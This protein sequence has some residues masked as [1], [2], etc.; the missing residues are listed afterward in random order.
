MILAELKGISKYFGSVT[1]VDSLNLTVKQG[2]ILAI[3]GPSG[4]G[5]TTLLQIISGLEKADKG[6]IRIGSETIFSAENETFL[7]PELRQVALVFQKYALWPH[8]NV[9]QNI[10]YPLKIKRLS[11]HTIKK[12]V[13]KVLQIIRLEGKEKRYPHELSGGE[14]QRVALARALVMKPKLLLLDEPLSNLDAKLREDMQ[15]E[16]KRIQQDLNL[17][18]IHVTHDQ[19]EAMGIADRLAVMNNGKIIQIGTPRDLYEQPADAFVAQFIGVSNLLQ[20]RI[21]D[22][23]QGRHMESTDGF[24]I[25]NVDPYLYN[26]KDL[27]L[28]IRPEDIKID[29]V[30]GDSSGRIIQL[31]YQGSIIDYEI[32]TDK[33][34]LH[35]RTS[36]QEHYESGEKVRFTLE[37]AT[38]VNYS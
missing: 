36:N 19:H 2:E 24:I 10:S 7:N 35:V 8:Y 29:R 37:R 34:L 16:I 27:T 14:Q 33:K 20:A 5:K 32:A 28:S 22:N 6:S 11:K 31:R 23:K 21:K 25:N 17:T 4:C 18:L 1:A 15:E 30:H 9:F 3:L 12:E 13:A 26:S 38:V